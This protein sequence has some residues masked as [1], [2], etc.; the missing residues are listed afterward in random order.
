MTGRTEKGTLNL[1]WS[2]TPTFKLVSGP[3]KKRITARS[4]ARGMFPFS[5][6][7]WGAS[8][9]DNPQCS[10][11]I[12]TTLANTKAKFRSVPSEARYPKPN[13]LQHF[14]KKQLF[15][16]EQ[17]PLCRRQL[18]VESRWKAER[19]HFAALML[20]NDADSLFFSRRRRGRS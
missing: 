18:Q 16:P 1:R 13:R 19:A 14:L 8:F 9:R 7:G 12:R 17:T 15:V 20:I 5:W 11:S 10:R 4:C 2:P 3:M 6:R